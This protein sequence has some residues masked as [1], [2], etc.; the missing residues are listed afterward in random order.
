[1][2]SRSF[3]SVSLESLSTHNKYA[4]VDASSWMI[5]YEKPH[6][7]EK[8]YSRVKSKHQESRL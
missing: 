8:E 3:S 2:L 7:N 5:P 4:F 1:M 6:N